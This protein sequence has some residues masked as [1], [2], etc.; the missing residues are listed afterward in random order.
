[1]RI[2]QH[3]GGV[4]VNAVVTSHIIFISSGIADISEASTSRYPLL[5]SRYRLLWRDEMDAPVWRELA[6]LLRHQAQQSPEREKVDESALPRLGKS[7]DL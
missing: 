2:A 7:S 1:M 4:P 3:A 5:T 6:T